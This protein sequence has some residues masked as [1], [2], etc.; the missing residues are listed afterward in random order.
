M[1][2][3]LL[4]L[5]LTL[6]TSSVFAKGGDNEWIPIVDLQQRLKAAKQ[7]GVF[8]EF[9]GN[10]NSFHNS[11]NDL[12]NFIGKLDYSLVQSYLVSR[13]EQSHTFCLQAENSLQKESLIK[14]VSDELKVHPQ[15]ASIK[16]YY[17]LTSPCM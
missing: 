9:E 1:K 12:T 13:S 14:V 7:I 3:I 4:S 15:D 5:L 10:L 2:N 8:V 16:T 17:T 6:S 11:I